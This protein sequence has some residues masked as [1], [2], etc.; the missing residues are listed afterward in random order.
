MGY[1]DRN[2]EGWR[3]KTVPELVAHLRVQN[4]EGLILAPA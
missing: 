1:Q 3:D 2:L 4:A